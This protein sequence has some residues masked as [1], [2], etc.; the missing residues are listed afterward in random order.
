MLAE[1]ARGT[2]GSCSRRASTRRGPRRVGQGVSQAGVPLSLSSPRDLLS[3]PPSRN[4]RDGD[5][6]RGAPPKHQIA[7]LR[8]R[9]Q[10]PV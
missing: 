5:R 6:G 4:L 10:V 8:L 7:H 3:L 9:A 1:R 2:D